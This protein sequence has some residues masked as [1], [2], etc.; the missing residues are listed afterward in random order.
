MIFVVGSGPA[1]ISCAQGLLAIGA[2]VTLLDAGQTLEPSRVVQI[3]ELTANSPANWTA[4]RTAFLKEGMGAGSAG[5]PLKLAYGSEFPYR[6][7]PGATPVSCDM[8]DSKGSY[9]QGGLSTVWGSA[10]L[11]YLQRDLSGWPITQEDLE[12][13][14]RAVL[15][16][17]P[18]A[19]RRDDLEA[20][21]P[22][23]SDTYAPLPMSRQAQSLLADLEKRR[24]RLGDAGVKFGTS[25]LAVKAQNNGTPGCVACGLC[26]YGCPHRLIYS[27]DSTLATLLPHPRFHYRSGITVRTVK[28][29]GAG[30]TINAVDTQNAFVRLEGDRVLL[31]AGVLGTASILLRSMERYNT[32]V[33]LSDSQYF[34]LPLLR[35]KGTPE[36]A[37]EQLHTLAQLFVEIL[38]PAISPYTI[39]L[40]TYTY[41]ELFR[42][43]II[44]KLGPL[45]PF[46]PLETFVGRLLLFQGYLHSVHSPHVEVALRRQD[47][48][49]AL[50]L[51]GV[52]NPDTSKT[53][54]KL[55]KKLSALIGTTGLFPLF[56]MLQPGK[57]GRGF[58][59]GGTFPMSHNPTEGQ[60]DIFGRPAGMSRIHAI[61][62]TVFPSIPATTITLTV[63]ANAYRIGSALNAYS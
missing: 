42:E 55:I 21:F 31:G 59:S 20:D 33:T 45:K 49:D 48:T 14:Y 53:V 24:D 12:P 10:V 51:R 60:T 63:M 62:S 52:P 15:R 57:P 30:V 54:R 6:A 27:S 35:L 8:A 47:G 61:D 18:L 5:I 50:H 26:M 11:P 37:T 46:F 38:D 7:V 41:N 39:H 34:L 28:E 13:G 17:M 3:S 1:G 32:P 16:W 19:G 36:V 40:Q 22:L 25:R 58:H 23:Y 44:Q 4:D 9:A 2:E 29:S 56:P 43:P